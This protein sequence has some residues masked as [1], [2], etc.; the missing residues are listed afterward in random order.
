MIT[1]TIGLGE[2]ADR[3]T[4][5]EIKQLRIQDPNR[6]IWIA[7]DLAD[8]EPY[9]PL[10]KDSDLTELGQVND[11]IFQLEDQAHDMDHTKDAQAYAK[12]SYEI[13]R[14]NDRRAELKRHLDRELGS[15]R[16]EQKSYDHA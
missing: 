12:I 11:Q 13:R 10:L 7:Q 14:L 5:L 9:R 3:L 2:L 8:L 4:I 16:R 15:Q 1:L 6:L